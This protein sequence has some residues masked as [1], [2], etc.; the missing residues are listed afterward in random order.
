MKKQSKNESRNQDQNP[1]QIPLNKLQAKR[2]ANIS[3]IDSKLLINKSVA[4][5]KNEFEWKIDLELLFF[6]KVCGKVVKRDPETDELLPV[7]FATVYVE[8]TDCNLMGF[9]PG[10]SS[11]SWL[12]PLDC[13]REVIS[14][15]TTDECGN[16]CVY[17]PRFEIDWILRWRKQRFCFP[18]IFKRPN[19]RDILDDLIPEPEKVRIPLPQPDPGPILRNGGL[20]LDYLKQFISSKNIEKLSVLQSSAEL[21]GSS[22]EIDQLYESTAFNKQVPPPF[23]REFRELS[24]ANK[25]KE[26]SAHMAISDKSLANFNP[27]YFIGPFKRCFDVSMPVWQQINDVPDITFRVTQ[28]IDGDGTEET[29]YSESFFDVRW[30]NTHISDVTLEA[31]QIALT[32]IDCD[33]EFH[34]PCGSPEISF[35]GYMPLHNPASPIPPYID[36]NGYAKRVNR[37][38]PSGGFYEALP[39]TEATAFSPFAGYFPLFGCN[40]HDDAQYYRL[41]YIHTPENSVTPLAQSTFLGHSWHVF[42]S[43]LPAHHVVPDADGWYEILD[44]DIGWSPEKLLLNWPT[45]RYANGLYEVVMELA[46]SAKAVVHTTASIKAH[47]DNRKPQGIFTLLRWNY[48]GEDNW[49]TVGLN[50]PVIQRTKGRAIDIEVSYEAS[51]DHLRSMQLTGNGC[52]VNGILSLKSA[53]DTVAWWHRN[54]ADNYEAKTA[55][56]YLAANMLPGAYGFHLVTDSRAFNPLKSA[57]LESDWVLNLKHIWKTTELRVSVVDI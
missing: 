42:K 7:P 16:F 18:T 21:G 22:S 19:L 50:C 46:N 44:P 52:G 31:S 51:S 39:E 3:N 38:H 37:P 56:Y 8:D 27:R 6:R 9:F 12:F 10:K 2:L 13:N 25:M 32:S 34:F 26:L 57:G 30:D 48:V 14:T 40:Q 54:G 49:K 11:W 43:G 55:V 45:Y 35:A 4:E 47:I 1:D 24:A 36:A 41:K 29:I 23:P 33:Q 20:T 53:V 5:I 15:V 28:D 17:I